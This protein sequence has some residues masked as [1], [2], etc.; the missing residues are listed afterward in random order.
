M[1]LVWGEGLRVPFLWLLPA[2]SITFLSKEEFKHAGGEEIQSGHVQTRE[3][4]SMTGGW[5]LGPTNLPNYLVCVALQNHPPAS[6]SRKAQ[7]PNSFI[8]V[9]QQ[10]SSPLCVQL[11]FFD[12][13]GA[14]VSRCPEHPHHPFPWAANSSSSHLH[15]RI[16]SLLWGKHSGLISKTTLPSWRMANTT[17]E[18]SL[19]T[20]LMF[21][22]GSVPQPRWTPACSSL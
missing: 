3:L 6:P 1:P 14:G 8:P 11:W 19:A 4:F 16:H 15:T 22:S 9:A 17:L 7:L 21:S 10:P 12:A 18:T 2:F 20:S 13:P 5:A